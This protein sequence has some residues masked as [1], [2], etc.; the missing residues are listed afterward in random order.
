MGVQFQVYRPVLTGY[1]E[2]P[3]G[4]YP[5]LPRYLGSDGVLLGTWERGCGT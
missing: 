1:T 5:Y 4:M 3:G 2:D